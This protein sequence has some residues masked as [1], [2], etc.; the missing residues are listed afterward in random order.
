VS[1]VCFFISAIVYEG[2]RSAIQ[3]RVLQSRADY[4]QI[5]TACVTL[6]RT[7]TN[8]SLLILPGDPIVPSLMRFLLPRYI[9]ASSNDV[10]LELHGGF[11]HYGF[12][13]RPSVADSKQCTISFY[14]E[15]G[16]SLL[17][18]ILLEGGEPIR[19]GG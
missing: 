12:R 14:T 16:E 1:A 10:M 18:T 11:E 3:N 17:T 5:I 13:A 4:P 6:K 15:K 8:D 2:Y 9:S 19:R 7:I